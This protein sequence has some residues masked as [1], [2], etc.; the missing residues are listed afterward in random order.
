[1]PNIIP[2]VDASGGKR[3]LLKSDI[4]ETCKSDALKGKR[5]ATEMRDALKT[6][7]GKLDSDCK[8]LNKILSGSPQYSVNVE[9]TRMEIQASQLEILSIIIGGAADEAKGCTNKLSTSVKNATVLMNILNLKVLSIKKSAIGSATGIKS[10]SSAWSSIVQSWNKLTAQVAN[11]QTV[12]G[13]RIQ[14]NGPETSCKWDDRKSGKADILMISQVKGTPG[15]TDKFWDGIKHPG[16][17][18]NYAAAAMALSCLGYQVT[19][20]DLNKKLSSGGY[21]A[22]WEQGAKVASGKNN[23]DGKKVDIGCY[24]TRDPNEKDK[25]GKQIDCNPVEGKV[26]LD[27]AL[28]NYLSNPDKYSAPIVHMPKPATDGG[29]WVMIVG[30]NADG[31]YKV[32]DT[33]TGKAGIN[34]EKLILQT[35]AS[36]TNKFAKNTKTNTSTYTA[37]VDQVVQYY[38]K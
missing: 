26:A 25:K 36:K 37:T 33:N 20:K 14:Q 6:V 1:M 22:S 8:H 13:K 16:S 21:Y 15:Y 31:S 10:M 19:A 35:D 4:L 28:T 17:S 34:G 2:R 23:L 7:S 32:L 30:K 9:R 5:E 3:F 18:C 11:A 24:N 27:N 12:K 38:V 29:H